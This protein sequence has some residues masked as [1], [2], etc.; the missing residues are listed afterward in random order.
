MRQFYI[1]NR[2][3]VTAAEFVEMRTA[4]TPTNLP[5]GPMTLCKV[6]I[7][8]KW[9]ACQRQYQFG[10]PVHFAHPIT[11]TLKQADITKDQS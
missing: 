11:I 6:L 3:R 5:A 7:D 2:V 10:Q 4:A 9:H 1:T 8:G